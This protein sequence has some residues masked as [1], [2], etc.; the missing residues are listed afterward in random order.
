MRHFALNHR[1]SSFACAALAGALFQPGLV[2]A[3]ALGNIAL[4]SSLGQPLRVVIP[5]ALSDGEILNTSCLKLVRDPAPGAPQLLTGRVSVE[6]NAANTRLIVTTPRP[7]DEPALR[8]SVQAGCG[9]TTRRDYVLLLDPQENESN[10]MVASAD[11]DEF[12][13]YI[14]AARPAAAPRRAQQVVAW[15]EPSAAPASVPAPTTF[16]PIDPPWPV[17]V[18]KTQKT[19]PA[20]AIVA[21]AEPSRQPATLTTVALTT[22]QPS[23]GFIPEAAAAS[24]SHASVEG[25]NTNGLTASRPIALLR[26]RDQAPEATLWTQTWPYGAVLLSI[27]AIALTALVKR[28]SVVAPAW[29]ASTVDNFSKSLMHA[30][31]A[32]D[33]F[34]DFGV[35]SEVAPKSLQRI[36]YPSAIEDPT[37]DASLDTLL[38][39]PEAGPDGIDE[40]VIRKAWA[41]L[42]SESAVD[43]GT[44]SI[45]KAIADA[46]RDLH[47]S[48]ADPAQAAID[49]A[50]DDDLMRNPKPRR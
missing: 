6:R 21:L 7:V 40:H 19:A 12:K 24:F 25:S 43:I 37:E 18:A 9:D 29:S 31:A 38:Q 20:A 42:A 17:A 41:T 48:P 32:A 16:K 10:A 2:S 14:G 28:R 45:L 23:S 11:V 34:A 47:I 5:V 33:T 50:L 27:G 8:L 35:M 36:A 44:D 13:H 4:Q 26:T 15:S 30:S 3:V 46:E 22:M 49:K 39:L 1:I